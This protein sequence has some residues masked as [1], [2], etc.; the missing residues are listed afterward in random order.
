[1]YRLPADVGRQRTSAEAGRATSSL[2]DR[3]GHESVGKSYGLPSVMGRAPGKR[4]FGRD[5]KRATCHGIGNGRRSLV[6]A[7]S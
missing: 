3:D 5:S 6:T 2:P 4:G 7:V 1:M